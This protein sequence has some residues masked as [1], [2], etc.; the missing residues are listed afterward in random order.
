MV[1]SPMSQLDGRLAVNVLVDAPV[2]LQKMLRVNVLREIHFRLRAGRAGLR[3]VLAADHGGLRQR[4]PH[5][6][7][8]RQKRARRQKAAQLHK[9]PA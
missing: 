1:L 7:Q 8:R 4:A 5:A 9:I 3:H 2:Q 6:G